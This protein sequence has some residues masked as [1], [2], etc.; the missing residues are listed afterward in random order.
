MAYFSRREWLIGL[1]LGI[2]VGLGV[3]AL[4]HFL[5]LSKPS[6]PGML[7][8]NWKRITLGDPPLMFAAPFDVEISTETSLDKH[9]LSIQEMHTAQYI[10]SDG[11]ALFASM[12]LYQPEE[13]PSMGDAAEGAIQEMIRQRTS[14]LEYQTYLCDFGRYKGY[15][16]RGSYMLGKDHYTFENKLLTYKHHLWQINIVY[17]TDDLAGEALCGRIMESLEVVLR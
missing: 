5:W 4:T 1:P 11:F 15:C 16:L 9:M 2:V 6:I 12:V 10:H 7:S 13:E 3:Y 17:Q 14:G 8:L